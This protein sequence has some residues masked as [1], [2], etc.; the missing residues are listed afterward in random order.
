MRK[1]SWRKCFTGAERIALVFH[2]VERG[3]VSRKAKDRGG[4]EGLHFA[5]PKD[6]ERCP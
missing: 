6:A 2:P 4:T 5:K 3:Y 1:A